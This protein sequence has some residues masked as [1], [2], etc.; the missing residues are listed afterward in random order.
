MNQHEVDHIKRQPLSAQVE[1]LLHNIS[2]DKNPEKN[3]EFYRQF[4][5]ILLDIKKANRE[6]KNYSKDKNLTL[7][8]MDQFVIEKTIEFQ[9][10]RI[11]ENRDEI[12]KLITIN[13]LD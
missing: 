4:R 2:N 11:Q 10:I 5:N 13:V 9:R 3:K 6:Y 8:Q 1:T 7:S 12:I